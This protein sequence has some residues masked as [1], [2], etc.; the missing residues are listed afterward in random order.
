MSFELTGNKTVAGQKKVHA[1]QGGS[2]KLHGLYFKNITW[3]GVEK[4]PDVLLAE[5]N[6]PATCKSCLRIVEAYK[7]KLKSR[8]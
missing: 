8:V 4:R 5:T 7:K 6:L 3:C 1:L 2:P